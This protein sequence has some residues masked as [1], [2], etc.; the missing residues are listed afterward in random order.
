MTRQEKLYAMELIWDDLRNDPESV[1]SP[2][3]HREALEE[4]GKLIE[5]GK[6]EWIPWEEAKKRLKQARKVK[7]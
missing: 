2:D 3:W 1:E 7:A 4:R 6:A 5:S